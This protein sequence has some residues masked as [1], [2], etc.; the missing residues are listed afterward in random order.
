MEKYIL[1]EQI[2]TVI[3]IIAYLPYIVSILKNKTKPDRTTWSVLFFI[4]IITFLA[5]KSVGAS[6]TLGV[7]LANVIGPFIIFLLSL[8][9]GE[10][11]KNKNDFKYLAISL[12]AI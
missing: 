1:Y 3:T 7:A 4:G 5:Y 6:T 8:K 10:G 9:F 12:I 11:W 2:A